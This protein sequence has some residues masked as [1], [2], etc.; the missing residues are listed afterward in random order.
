MF[1]FSSPRKMDDNPANALRLLG[2]FLA[3]S[4]RALDRMQDASCPEPCRNVCVNPARVSSI[5]CGPLE[6]GAHFPVLQ[7]SLFGLVA[8]NDAS[9]PMAGSRGNMVTPLRVGR[10]VVVEVE[11]HV[12][13]LALSA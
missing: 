4:A 9:T 8:W 3:F 7:V 12:C 6:T 5:A 1:S 13:P 10:V 2:L 11:E